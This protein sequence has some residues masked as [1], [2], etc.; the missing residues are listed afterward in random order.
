[1]QKF[2]FELRKERQFLPNTASLLKLHH[3]IR[4]A[5]VKQ[6]R[7]LRHALRSTHQDAI[8]STRLDALVAGGNTLHGGSTVTVDRKSR[9]PLRY[10]GVQSYNTSDIHSIARRTRI[11]NDDFVNPFYIQICFSDQFGQ[12]DFTQFTSVHF[13]ELGSGFDERCTNPID[14]N[15]VSRISH[16]VSLLKIH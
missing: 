10:S 14:N 2:E 15:H 5:F 4:K 1:M 9:N 8:A 16:V 12:S 11:A 7:H 3:K 6:Q 13:G